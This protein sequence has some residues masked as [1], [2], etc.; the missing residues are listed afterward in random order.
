MVWQISSTQMPDMMV[1]QTSNYD[2]LATSSLGDVIEAIDVF[3]LSKQM[4]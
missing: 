2:T 3:A 4:K 1:K